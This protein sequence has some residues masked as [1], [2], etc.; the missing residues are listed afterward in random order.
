MG[1]VILKTLETLTYK[2]SPTQVL[3]KKIKKKFLVKKDAS[4]VFSRSARYSYLGVRE[5]HKAR[6]IL[7]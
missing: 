6:R 7:R 5:P 3:F 2:G 1:A 4:K